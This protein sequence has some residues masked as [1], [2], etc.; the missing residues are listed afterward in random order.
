MKLWVPHC[1]LLNGDGGLIIVADDVIVTGVLSAKWSPDLKD[2]RCD[3]D[4]MLIANHV[5]YMQ[6][7]PEG[8]CLKIFII[9]LTVRYFRIFKRYKCI[10]CIPRG[11]LESD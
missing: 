7:F 8:Y 10:A 11:M 9:Q 4:P 3:L 5:R 6:L 1:F 2:V